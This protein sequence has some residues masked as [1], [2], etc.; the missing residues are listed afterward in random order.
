MHGPIVYMGTARL[1]L[2]ALMVGSTSSLIDRSRSH[3]TFLSMGI[4]CKTLLILDLQSGEKPLGR[5]AM[6][7]EEIPGM[8]SKR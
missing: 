2:I 6:L 1:G 4:I 7:M 3:V 5:S 8:F